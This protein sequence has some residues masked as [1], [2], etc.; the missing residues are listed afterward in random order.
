MQDDLRRGALYAIA[1]AGAFSLTGACVKAASTQ[2]PNEVVVFF[3]SAV[4]LLLLLP[5][6]LRG[7]YA[8]T[9]RTQRLGGHLLRAAF[10]VC[11]MYCFFFAIAHLHLAEAIL[12]TYS[13]PLWIPFIAWAWL[14]ERPAPLTLAASLLGFVGLAVIAGPEGARLSGWAGLVGVASGL[15]AAAAMVSIRRIS[16]TEP[17][18]RIVFYFSLLA[19]LI[20]A[21]PLLWAWKR[22]D[23]PTLWLLLGAGATATA[24]QLLLTRAYASAP[25][26]RVG[27][28]T[29]AAVLFSALLAWLI[30]DEGV[31]GRFVLGAVA[32]VAACVLAGWQRK[33]QQ[34]IDD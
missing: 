5:W 16:D 1:A 28:F 25:A 32:V 31:E 6:M 17:A 33:E 19:T 10:G 7:G 22:P 15:L 29:Y 20:S 2:S 3:R 34:L 18:A 30:W 8:A 27:P 26:A 23:L 24:G 9:V 4:S 13:T 21:L 14:G 11:A 12:L